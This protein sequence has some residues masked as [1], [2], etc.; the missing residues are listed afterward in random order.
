MTDADAE[1]P[2]DHPLT[3]VEWNVQAKKW[4][5]LVAKLRL[6]LAAANAALEIAIVERD[7]ARAD[8]D[9]MREHC[10]GLAAEVE[11]CAEKVRGVITGKG[12]ETT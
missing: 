1:V 11:A 3:D 12:Q 6:E 10:Q 4:V 7:V 2:F 5:E 8:L 9:E